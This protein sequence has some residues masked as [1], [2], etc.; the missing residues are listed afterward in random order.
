M[1]DQRVDREGGESMIGRYIFAF[2]AGGSV[3][4]FGLLA[5]A[6]IVSG[7]AVAMGVY[8]MMGLAL[9]FLVGGVAAVGVAAWLRRQQKK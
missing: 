4:S 5:V 8:D 7:G 3:V 9:V 2:I 6:F 1:D